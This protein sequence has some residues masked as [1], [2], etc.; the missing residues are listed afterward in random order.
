MRALILLGTMVAGLCLVAV[1]GHTGS[2]AAGMFVLALSG[3]YFFARRNGAGAG[4]GVA[5]GQAADAIFA[6]L[7][8]LLLAQYALFS[9]AVRGDLFVVAAILTAVFLKVCG[10]RD[11]RPG[12]RALTVIVVC[13]AALSYRFLCPDHWQFGAWWE[14]VG[15]D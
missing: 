1:V 5:A 2:L 6:G 7:M 13:W 8:M 3:C 11:E 10:A 15:M 4:L 9:R 14:L 12:R